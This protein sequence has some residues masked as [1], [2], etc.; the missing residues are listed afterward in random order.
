MLLTSHAYNIQI[1]PRGPWTLGR[2]ESS[3]AIR[4]QTPGAKGFLSTFTEFSV[5][6]S[7]SI[8]I[9]TDGL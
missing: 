4:A 8:Q 6:I 9:I 1:I 3:G 5:H 2:A 7:T